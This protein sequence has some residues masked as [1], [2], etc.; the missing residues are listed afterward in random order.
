MYAEK[1]KGQSVQPS[2]RSPR[3]PPNARANATKELFE[4]AEPCVVAKWPQFQVPCL[5]ALLS[6]TRGFRM[7]TGLCN[8]EEE[9]Q[10]A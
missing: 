10:E 7:W 3:G 9:V 5:R 1:N 8:C 4:I 6:L 2:P